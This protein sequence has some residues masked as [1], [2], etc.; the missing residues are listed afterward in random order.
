MPFTGQHLEQYYNTD[1]IGTKTLFV[2]YKHGSFNCF[3]L[4]TI[5][6]YHHV[7]YHDKTQQKMVGQGLALF[8]KCTCELKR[9]NKINHNYNDDHNKHVV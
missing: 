2:D 4:R 3:V 9:L 7:V 8:H 6:K 1:N 5:K